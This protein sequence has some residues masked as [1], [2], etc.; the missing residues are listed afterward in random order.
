MTIVVTI[1]K[2]KIWVSKEQVNK[3]QMTRDIRQLIAKYSHNEVLNPTDFKFMLGILSRHPSKTEKIGC[4]VSKLIVKEERSAFHK[5]SKHFEVV[6]MDGSTV[7]FSWVKCVAGKK[8]SKAEFSKACRSAINQ[9]IIDYRN[10][11]KV[12]NL[13]RIESGEVLPGNEVHVDHV[14]PFADI[15]TSFVAAYNIDFDAIGYT[16]T[17]MVTEFVDPE[18]KYSFA[19]YHRKHAKLRLITAGDNLR[20]RVVCTKGIE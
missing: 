13:F 10:Q 15:V 17:G 4:G 6:R 16:D 14:L 5:L 18:L 20:R 3:A 12:G 1:S 9:Q 8:S 7:D 19:E 11:F 2:G